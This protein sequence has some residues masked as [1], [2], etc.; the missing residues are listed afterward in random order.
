[1][2]KKGQLKE[3]I[4]IPG[5]TNIMLRDVSI[6]QNSI[7]RIFKGLLVLLA[8]YLQTQA[9]TAQS[10]LAPSRTLSA[11]SDDLSRLRPPIPR[12][13]SS[14]ELE[15]TIER[16]V[17]FLVDTQ[18]KDGAWGGPQWTGGVDSDPIP[19][20]FR[21]FDVAVTAMCL[22]AILEVTQ[23]DEVQAAIQKAYTFLMDRT[24]NI[25]RAGPGDLPQIWAHCY[26]IQTFSKMY[27]QT[28]DATAKEELADA[29]HTHGTTRSLAV[30]S[31][32]LVLLRQWHGQADQS[33]LQFR[34][35]RRPGGIG[36]G[37]SHWNQRR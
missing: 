25:K 9:A 26:C 2:K 29:I 4:P 14:G 18:R 10:G 20:S 37:E 8:S 21:S 30:H 7:A 3:A 35:L 17:Q 6:R 22:E 32:W 34:K 28:Q 33:F 36:Q 31:W 15:A 13:V 24:D 12:P 16:G 27:S 1:M 19:G 5:Y 23:T 11:K